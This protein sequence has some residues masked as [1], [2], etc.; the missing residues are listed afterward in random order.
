MTYFPAR[1]FCENLSFWITFVYSAKD[2]IYF[3]HIG[4]GNENVKV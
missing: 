1:S 2:T 4:K 3:T